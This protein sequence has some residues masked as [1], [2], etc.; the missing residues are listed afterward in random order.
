VTLFSAIYILYT[1][2]IAIHTEHS[3]LQSS[4]IL[5]SSIALYTTLLYTSTGSSCGLVV[6]M[7]SKGNCDY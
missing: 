5:H 3:I 2:T 1:S 4:E 6:M 7:P